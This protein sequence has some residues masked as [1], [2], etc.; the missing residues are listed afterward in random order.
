MKRSAL[1]LLVALIP[2]LAFAQGALLQAGPSA[3]GRVPQYV[4]QG[5]SQAIVQ[6]SGP[7]AGGGP[8]LGLAELLL[9]MRGHGQPP[10]A[11]Q[12]SGPLGTNFCNYDAPT[13]NPTGYHYLCF[14]PNAQGGGLLAYGASGTATQLPFF[15]NING[16]PIQFPG[17]GTGDVV[18]PQTS[19][20]GDFAFW[21]NDAG[22]VLV[23]GGLLLPGDR[24]APPLI[25]GPVQT[26]SLNQILQVA[27]AYTT[28]K[29]SADMV[30]A[31]LGNFPA[32]AEL[33]SLTNGSF[34]N[35]AVVGATSIPAGDFT[36]GLATWPSGGGAFYVLSNNSL[37]GAVGVY[38]AAGA[39]V[40]NA[41]LDG[42]N[43]VAANCPIQ[44]CVGNSGFDFQTTYGIEPD[45]VIEAKADGSA[46]TGQVGGIVAI[47]NAAIQN[48]GPSAAF[49]V[50]SVNLPWKTG[51]ASNNGTAITGISL[52]ATSATG[53]A[54]SQAVNQVG[55]SGGG[56]PLLVSQFVDS[57]GGWN[58]TNDTA[59]T[60]TSAANTFPQWRYNAGSNTQVGS[61]MSTAATGGSAAIAS[62]MQTGSAGSNASLEVIDGANLQILTGSGL[63]GGILIAPGAGITQISSPLTVT[64]NVNA[65]VYT[66]TTGFALD[67][68]LLLRGV[69]TISSGF[70]TGASVTSHNGAAAFRVNVGTGGT[71]A[72]GVVG[73]PAAANGWN[74]SANDITTTST[75]IY[76]T[77]QTASTTT[78][79]TFS[80]FGTAAG[81]P[82]VAGDI[83]SI[84]CSAY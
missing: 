5:N 60:T 79:A 44:L 27:A 42:A 45:V 81:A 38:A 73:L 47:L 54:N 70:G 23:D 24:I 74:C 34:S 56:A 59:G 40:P 69:P 13:T 43:V 57:L 64:G 16:V 65:P 10:F 55:L 78:S 15:M 76:M 53:P 25:L 32:N 17:A 84:S 71:A 46:P 21:G 18:G 26:D 31:V 28:P 19:T 75:A 7:A 36:G 8:G 12:G 61:L 22:T 39:N 33:S 3:P 52:G 20:P 49:L 30:R 14:G 41:I 50:A 83:L 62:I 68:A 6:D 2:S 51:L 35:W 9:T 4:S 1:G 11:G 58:V 66:P 48:N 63:T 77:K 72:T 37:V 82:W 29:Q 67:S 80:G